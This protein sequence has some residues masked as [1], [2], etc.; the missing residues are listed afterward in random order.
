LLQNTMLHTP[1]MLFLLPMRDPLDERSPWDDLERSDYAP[2]MSTLNKPGVSCVVVV[3][4]NKQKNKSIIQV[5]GK[6]NEG[7]FLPSGSTNMSR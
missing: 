5:Q 1:Y 4:S 7:V 6:R 2:F 3:I